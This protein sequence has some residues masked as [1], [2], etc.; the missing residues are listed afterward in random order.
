MACSL[1]EI[2]PDLKSRSCGLGLIHVN[3][4][5]LISKIAFIVTLA[6]QTDADVLVITESWL[7]KS[8]PDSDVYLTC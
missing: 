2:T 5:S 8:M 7:K 1:L 3:A 6:S 4:K